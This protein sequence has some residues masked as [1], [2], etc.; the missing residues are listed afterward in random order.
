MFRPAIG[1]A[2]LVA[3]DS[4][5]ERLSREVRIQAGVCGF[6]LRTSRS[7][8]RN[9]QG[10]NSQY[11]AAEFDDFGE[12][13]DAAPPAAISRRLSFERSA[14]AAAPALLRTADAAPDCAFFGFLSRTAHHNIE[15]CGQFPDPRTWQ[16]NEV[17]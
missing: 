6:R 14:A 12:V 8:R 16:R 7:G 13:P 4:E 17:S 5:V 15:L 3:L 11:D 10:L 2:A 9:I 1:V